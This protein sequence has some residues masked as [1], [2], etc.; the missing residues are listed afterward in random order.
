MQA[1]FTVTYVLSSFLKAEDFVS[2]YQTER[3][4]VIRILILIVS[5]FKPKFLAWSNQV[6]LLTDAH[7]RTLAKW[8]ICVVRSTLFVF[9]CEMVWVELLRFW[10]VRRVMMQS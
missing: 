1:C 2:L 9:L 8:K 6:S 5:D 7:S 4:H 3:R 10:E